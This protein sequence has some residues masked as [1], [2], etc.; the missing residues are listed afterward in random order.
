MDYFKEIKTSLEEN[1]CSK[2][3]KALNYDQDFCANASAGQN[4]CLSNNSFILIYLEQAA[5]ILAQSLNVL[6]K[7]TDNPISKQYQVN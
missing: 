5:T 1:D 6:C 3:F 7:S 2:V 4:I